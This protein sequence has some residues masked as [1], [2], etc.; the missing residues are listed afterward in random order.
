MAIEVI[1]RKRPAVVWVYLVMDVYDCI[2]HPI[3]SFR[4]L[5]KRIRHVK[6]NYDHTQSNHQPDV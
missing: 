6:N 1:V 3:Q 5:K 2:R 4:S